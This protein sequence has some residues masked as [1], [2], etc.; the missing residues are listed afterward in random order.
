MD[1]VNEHIL[2]VSA[3]V[4]DCYIAQTKAF[5]PLE[6][7]YLKD[8]I[9]HHNIKTILDVGT[10]E[11]TFISGLASMTPEVLYEAIDIDK[12]LITRAQHKHHLKNLAFKT[13]LFDPSFP[14]VGYDLITAR[15]AVEHMENIP[16]FISEAYRRL[17]NGGLLLMTEYYIDKL[18]SA[19]EM[20]RLFR[21]KELEFYLKFGS[22]PSISL[23]LPKYLYDSGF[24]G[25]ESIFRHISPS[26]VGVKNFYDLIVSYTRLYGHIEPAIWTGEIKAKIIKYCE[27]A[28]KKN[29]DHEDILLIS[30]T[31]GRRHR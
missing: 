26:T 16:Q 19:N 12:A 23:E 3:Y 31:M 27:N 24:S 25:I 4:E 30:H 9:I 10:G 22:H 2:E 13:L 11:G 15:F 20:W 5:S 21:D 29:P 1:F 7:P 18:D 14:D 28:L 8:I 6:Y 17:R